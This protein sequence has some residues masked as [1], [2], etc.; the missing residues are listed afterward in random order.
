MTVM[1]T[2]TTMVLARLSLRRT[3]TCGSAPRPSVSLHVIT[4]PLSNAVASTC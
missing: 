2:L 4:W 1:M 3:E